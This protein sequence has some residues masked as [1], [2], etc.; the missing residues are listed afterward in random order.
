MKTYYHG[1]AKNEILSNCPVCDLLPLAGGEP[2]KRHPLMGFL[3]AGTSLTPSWSCPT[4]GSVFDGENNLLVMGKP[5]AWP[6]PDSAAD[7]DLM[8]IQK[9]INNID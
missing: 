7:A 6:D 9:P 2:I 4:C 5:P 3:Y 8:Y 1:W